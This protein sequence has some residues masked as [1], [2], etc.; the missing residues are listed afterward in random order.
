[1]S[2]ALAGPRHH[3]IR[4]RSRIEEVRI[5]KRIALLA[6]LCSGVLVLAGGAWAQPP[7]QD[8]WWARSTAGAPIVLDGILN[9][10]EWALAETKVIDWA[11]DAGIPGSGFKPEGGFL[12]TDPTHAELKFLTRGNIL[13]MGAVIH[14]K[15][16]GGSINFNRFD[17]LLMS[18][19]DHLAAT[20]PAPPTEHFY[21]WWDN[22]PASTD[23]QP[24]TRQPA[25]A[26]G[27]FAQNPSYTGPPRT[28][29]QVAA[30]DAVTVVHGVQNSDANGNDTDWTVEM[31]FDLS[32]T[33]YDITKP[34]GDIVE[35]N[36]SIYD[37]DNYWPLVPINLAANRV[38]WQGPWGN[39]SGYN[40]VRIMC[41]PNVT[42]NTPNL[43]YA[44]PEIIIP[45][46]H[47]FPAPVID[48]NLSDAVWAHASHFD[49]RYGDDALRATYP[50]VLKWRGG[51]F[52]PTVNGG[53][54]AV[55]DPG[56]ATIKYFFRDDSLYFGFDV[57]DA[58]VQSYALTDRMDG[59][60]VGIYD[61]VL[62]ESFDNTLQPHRL[63]FD[64]SPLGTARTADYLTTLVANGG[65]RVKL[66]L[67]P[68]TTLDTTGVTLDT[69]YTAELLID[70]TKIG[71]PHN[72][73]D[74]LVFFSVD[75]YDGD[76]LIP[77]TDS[78]GTRTWWGAEYD[79]TCC[80]P[81]GYMDPL[82]NVLTGVP[83]SDPGGNGYV[84]LSM[85]PNPFRSSTTL[86]YR[87]PLASAVKLELF[88][89]QG[90][91]VHSSDLGVQTAG[92][93][94]AGVFGFR[95]KTGLYL[96]RL[97]M[98]DPASGAERAALSGRVLVVK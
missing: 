31:K 51:Q 5:M 64:V 32:A 87:L 44:A 17:G 4:S 70:L 53:Q 81:W 59:F 45:N 9:E 43:P 23:P 88:D 62:R 98:T 18:I 50:G 47:T 77:F 93:Q 85:A 94:S 20:H 16:I 66:Q 60:V 67:K 49:I 72:R 97:R 14:D 40:E 96:Y 1:V 11:T 8:I 46:G 83:P 79:N 28:P 69:G 78:Y 38:W 84:L 74:G 76:S 13:Y 71:Y 19:K 42:V 90:R 3:T 68:G 57:R 92:E 82:E 2:A 6:A 12:P 55:I 21:V 52:Q 30:W 7:R 75:M 29:A 27:P 58:F 37:C 54:A 56:D 80:P 35:F 73:G 22:D 86:R 24:T 34:A 63:T 91:V 25:F 26:G 61:R 15:S 39:A 10:P 41:R 95:G 48:G 36:I 33:G 65:A 89:P